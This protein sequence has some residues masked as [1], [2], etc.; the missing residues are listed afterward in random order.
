M[1]RDALGRPEITP[2]NWIS[3]HCS[4]LVRPPESVC[5]CTSAVIRPVVDRISWNR[6]ARQGVLRLGIGRCDGRKNSCV[7]IRS[8]LFAEVCQGPGGGAARPVLQ[9]REV[10]VDDCRL[11]GRDTAP[12]HASSHTRGRRPRRR[13]RRA[14]WRWRRPWWRR[15]RTRRRRTLRGLW[16]TWRRVWR[17][18]RRNKLRGT[19]RRTRWRRTLRRLW[20]TWRRVWRAPRRILP[21]GAYWRGAHRRR[22]YCGSFSQRQP[23]RRL[24]AYRRD[25]RGTSEHCRSFFRRQSFA[26]CRTRHGPSVRQRLGPRARGCRGTRGRSRSPG[27][28]QPRHRQ[29]R[30]AIA[31]RTGALPR[32]VLWFS[33]A[34]VAWRRGPRLVRTAVLAL[35]LLRPVRLRLLAVCL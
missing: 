1:F 11:H 35:R 20:Q 17:A 22:A 6:S 28:R 34:L 10:S 27:V 15:R 9:R 14:W 13:R 12:R 7:S 8:S 3:H 19:R 4:E 25:A 26:A 32:C 29:R 21:C 23:F 5:A 33:L 31:I 30:V 2:H 16:R 24:D 18:P